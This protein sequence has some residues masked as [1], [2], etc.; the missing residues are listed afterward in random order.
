MAAINKFQKDAKNIDS[1]LNVSGRFSFQ[2]TAMKLVVGDIVQKLNLAPED[3]L[4]DIGC[5][6]GDLTIPLSFVCEKVMGIDGVDTIERLKKRTTE[7]PNIETMAGDFMELEITEKYD[8]IL[9][10]SVLMYIESYEQ[11]LDFVLKAAKCLKSGG[12][13]LVGDVVNS[14]RKKRFSSTRTGE[15]VNKEYREN[16]KKLTEADKEAHEESEDMKNLWILDDF[17]LMKLLLDVRNAGYESYL[18]P[19]KHELPFGYTRDDILIYAW[20]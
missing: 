7:I 14:S 16:M 2:Q 17:Y 9:I 18:L 11:K 1:T 20:N 12:R 15:K 6:C 8:C 19:Q 5:N 10:Y 3:T 13:L 4:M